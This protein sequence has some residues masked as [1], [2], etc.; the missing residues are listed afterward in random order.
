MSLIKKDTLFRNCLCQTKMKIPCC[1]LCSRDQVLMFLP[2]LKQL[3][4]GLLKIWEQ[5]VI[6]LNDIIFTLIPI[7]PVRL[8]IPLSKDK[9]LRHSFWTIDQF[10]EFQQA[11]LLKGRFMTQY[12]KSGV[13]SPSYRHLVKK[14]TGTTLIEPGVF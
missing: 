5:L 9:I 8:E 13:S 11:R 12:C 7:N 2:S 1:S 14:H 6:S 4:S 3:V 10:K